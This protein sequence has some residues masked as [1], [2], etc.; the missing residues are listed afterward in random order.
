MIYWAL[1]GESL[2]LVDE[3]LERLIGHFIKVSAEKQEV[4]YIYI[5]IYVL[6]NNSK[7]KHWTW[8]QV[9]QL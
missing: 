9:N 6:L 5:Y 1:S 7:E 2:Y 4:I 3:N 8:V